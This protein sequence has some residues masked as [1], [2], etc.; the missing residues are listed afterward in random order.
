MGTNN[1]ENHRKQCAVEAR[2]TAFHHYSPRLKGTQRRFL[3]D[4]M[5]F[6][7]SSTRTEKL[8]TGGEIKNVENKP[9]TECPETRGEF[10]GHMI[11]GDK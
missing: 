2:E 11:P 8:R 4:R 6:S 7:D 5:E 1:G 9:E 10:T 3:V